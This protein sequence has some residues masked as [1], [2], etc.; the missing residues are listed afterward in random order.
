MKKKRILII[1]A[2]PMSNV[3]N[4][5]KTLSAFF[6]NYPKEKLAQL[7]FSTTLPDNDICSTYFKISDVDMLQRRLGKSQTCGDVVKAQSAGQN[8]DSDQVKN[9]KKGNFSRLLREF[10]WNSKWKTQE[11]FTWLDEFNPEVVF[12]LA[13]DCIFSHKICKYIVHKYDAKLAMYITD[14]YVLPRANIDVWGHVRRRMIRRHMRKSIQSANELFTIS[15]PMRQCYKE[16]YGKDSFVAANMYEPTIL[17]DKKKM[18]N[19]NIMITYAGGLH[20]NRHLTILKI[21]EAIK[22]I[23]EKNQG[24]K[25]K[26]ILQIFSGSVLKQDIMEC[27]LE[28]KCCIWGGMLQ[29][30]ELE[31]KLQRSDF[32]LHVES[33][34]KRNICDTKLSLS[35]KI[36]EYMSYH[37]PLIAVGPDEVASMKYLVDCACCITDIDKIK[38]IMEDVLFDDEKGKM[39]ADKAYEK[40]LNNHDKK[41]MQPKI[42]DIINNM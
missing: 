36:P 24:S 4:N 9:I 42:I 23:N 26:I 1:S 7:Y 27:L 17:Y 5:G 30:N 22:Q 28:S 13:G 39:L 3:Y 15:E 10:M 16:L 19:D 20:Y 18:T 14:D 11:L 12:F 25:K 41:K 38:N 34:K 31:E 32:L 29:S 35:T 6:D 21:V 37:K 33:F 2:N 8:K 40:Y